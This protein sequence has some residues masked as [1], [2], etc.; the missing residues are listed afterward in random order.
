[1]NL[2]RY[3]AAWPRQVARALPELKR[4]KNRKKEQ[5]IE[6]KASEGDK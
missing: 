4:S 6:W 3:E 1:M 5:I 2:T